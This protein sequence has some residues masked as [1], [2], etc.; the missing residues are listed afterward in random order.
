MVLEAL[1]SGKPVVASHV[2]AIHE[3][4]RA[5]VTGFLIEKDAREVEAFAKSISRLLDDIDLRRRMGAA[6]REKME[7]EFD[8]SESRRAYTSLFK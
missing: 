8:R 1:A 3:A 7:H 4:V 5:G 6:G 2:G